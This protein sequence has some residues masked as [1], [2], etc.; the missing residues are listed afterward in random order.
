MNGL[1]QD[2]RY[3]LRALR[4]N[5]G[6]AITSMA[7]SALIFFVATAAGYVAA[8]CATQVDPLVALRYE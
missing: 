5:P 6:F 7:V 1:L 4:A 2:L 8:R 3:G